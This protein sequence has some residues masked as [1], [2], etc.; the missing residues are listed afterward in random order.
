MVPVEPPTL[1]L[2]INYERPTFFYLF[3]SMG[4][5]IVCDQKRIW[6]TV[7]DF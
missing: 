6:K 7:K 5:V 1:I 2:A 3:L 4:Q